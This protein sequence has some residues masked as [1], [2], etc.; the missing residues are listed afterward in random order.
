R[1]D[2]GV[3]LLDEDPSWGLARRGPRLLAFSRGAVGLS[4]PVANA[5]AARKALAAWLAHGGRR[6]GK[7]GGGRLMTASGRSAQALLT[8]LSKPVPLPGNLAPRAK[9]PAW[10]WMR[11]GEPLRAG[12]LALDASSTGLVARGLVVASSPILS[13]APPAEC[14]GGIGCVRAGLGPAGIGALSIALDQLGL[15]PQ[16]E[17]RTAARATERVDRIDARQLGGPRSLASALRITPLFDAP[18]ADGPAL[19][20][21]LDL[22]QIDIALARL[23]PLDALRGA[24]AAGAY[25]AHLVYGPLLRNAGPLTLTGNPASGNAAEVEL[26]LP[27]R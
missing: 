10:I 5:K 16:P 11:F 4:A 17:L 19:Q 13:G 15:P 26:R 7:V 1:G 27:L 24:L 23:T 18:V 3:D 6:A 9:G 25:A 8:G 2:V 14:E 20:A 12:V 21:T 22:A